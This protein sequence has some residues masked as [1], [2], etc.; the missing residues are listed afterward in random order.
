[1]L[2]GGPHWLAKPTGVPPW[3]TVCPVQGLLSLQ[4]WCESGPGLNA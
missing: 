3:L 4:W 1:M 2:R